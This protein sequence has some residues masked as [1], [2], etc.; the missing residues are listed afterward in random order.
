MP[1]ALVAI[2]N[3]AASSCLLHHADYE[4]RTTYPDDTFWETVNATNIEKYISLPESPPNEEGPLT[5]IKGSSHEKGFLKAKAIII[6][7]DNALKQKER[8]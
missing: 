3:M 7:H 6:Q 4:G 2:P 5:E 8:V 1:Y